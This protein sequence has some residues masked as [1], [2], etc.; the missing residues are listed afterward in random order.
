ML[1]SPAP[2]ITAVFSSPKS[3]LAP[4]HQTAQGELI[5]ED[6]AWQVG[7]KLLE[8]TF[9]LIYLGGKEQSSSLPSPGL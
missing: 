6:I 3:T 9:S 1:K 8:Q 4:P 5:V 2:Q 7:C